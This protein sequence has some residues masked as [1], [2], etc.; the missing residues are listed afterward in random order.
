MRCDAAPE[1]VEVIA[2][3]E[4]FV[5]IKV[6]DFYIGNADKWRERRMKKDGSIFDTFEDAKAA[7][8]ADAR[9]RVTGAEAELQHEKYRLQKCNNL[10]APNA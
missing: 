8:V 1:P 6:R 5:T 4:C 2:E 7:L 10:K 9:R 3:T